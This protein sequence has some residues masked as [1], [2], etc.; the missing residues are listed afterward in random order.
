M[1]CSS[2]NQA[3][4]FAARLK[5]ELRVKKLQ[6]CALSDAVADLESR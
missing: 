6:R 2:S 5:E 3:M 4:R 1:T